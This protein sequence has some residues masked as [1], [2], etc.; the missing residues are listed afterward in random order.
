M[1]VYALKNLNRE[2]VRGKC[3]VHYYSKLGIATAEAIIAFVC[4]NM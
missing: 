1:Y 4:C 3:W 2:R